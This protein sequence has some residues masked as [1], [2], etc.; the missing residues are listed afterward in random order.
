MET[1]NGVVALEVPSVRWSAPLWGCGLLDGG[2]LVAAGAGG[3]VVLEQGTGVVV[4]EIEA[5]PRSAAVPVGGGLVFLTAGGVLRATTSRGETRWE[6]EVPAL[7]APLVWHDTVFVAEDEAV[8]AFDQFGRPLWRAEV[9]GEVDGALTGLPGRGVLVP[10][11]GD[12]HVGYLE[13]GPGGETRRVPAHL[14]PGD[15]VVPLAGGL[16]ALP[17]WPERDDL[18]EPHPTVSIVDSDTG[19]V[20]QHQRLRAEVRGIVAGVGG[21][22]AVASSPTWEYW[23]KYHGWP[24]FDLRDDCTVLVLDAGGPR[25]TWTAGRPITG[26]L[27]VAANGDLLVPVS[28]ELVSLG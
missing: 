27:A 2:L 9:D 25:G 12:D 5:A 4:G 15:L 17:G 11:R 3:Y 26:P 14:P 6:A 21:L 19:A 24:G 23:T 10:V 18:G 20:L 1:E 7:T 16:L 13:L 22:V 8:R 28:G